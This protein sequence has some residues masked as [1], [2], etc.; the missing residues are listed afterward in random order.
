M[1]ESLGSRMVSRSSVYVTAPW[2]HT[3][4]E[5][6]YNAIIVAEDPSWDRWAWLDFVQRCERNAERVRQ[7]H[8]GPR[9]L[10]VD[11]VSCSD[12]GEQLTSSDPNL[13]LPHPRAH[14]RAFVLVPWLEAEPAATLLG[15][16]LSEHL[17]AL[18]EGERAGV[19]RLCD[20]TE[21]FV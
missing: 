9:T 6:F 14:Q 5:D 16:P 19:R 20:Q 12:A 17:D 10:D 18:P 13:T 15:V 21:W 4:Q 11:I 3:D 8:W 7:R 2:G 1:A